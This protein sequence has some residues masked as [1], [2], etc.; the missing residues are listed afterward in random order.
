MAEF[1]LLS[2]VIFLHVKEQNKQ[3]SAM[4][5]NMKNKIS[6]QCPCKTASNAFWKQS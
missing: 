5:N 3:M 6:A 1:A 4:K 2:A